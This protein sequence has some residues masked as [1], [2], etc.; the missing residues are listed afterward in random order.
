MCDGHRHVRV[1][2]PSSAA[3]LVEAQRVD[4]TARAVS[5]ARELNGHAQLIV[6][7]AAVQVWI[8]ARGGG[9]PTVVQRHKAGNHELIQ[10]MA[11]VEGDHVGKVMNHVDVEIVRLLI[12][13]NVEADVRRRCRW[14]QRRWRQRRWWRM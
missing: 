8:C 3:L 4:R 9:A 5:T 13:F 12:L 2:N 11:T 14:N 1:P 10:T 6:D 7:H